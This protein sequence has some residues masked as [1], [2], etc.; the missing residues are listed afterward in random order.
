MGK[1]TISKQDASVD[2][3][4]AD[5]IARYEP[6]DIETELLQW[7]YSEYQ[8]MRQV[9]SQK[10]PE[11]NDRTLIEFLDDCQ[12]RANAYVPSR[13][14]QGKDEWQANI[15]TQYTRNKIKAFAASA[16]KTP[17]DVKMIARNTENQVSIRRAEIM[18][19]MVRASYLAYGNNPEKVIFNDAWNCL[20]NGTKISYDGFLKTKG[21]VK[22]VTS[23]DQVTGEVKFTEKEQIIEDCAIEINISPKNF[24]IKNAY[25]SDVQKQPT[26]AWVELYDEERF[27]AEFGHYKNAKFVR[28][29][30]QIISQNDVQ[31]FFGNEWVNRIEKKM[32]EVVR[33]YNKKLDRY[34]T[35]T[36]G[37]LLLNS[38]LL[39]G[40][41][42]KRYPF[43]KSGF[44][45]FANTEFFW[46]NSMANILMANQDVANTFI[47]GMVDKT[48]RT[49]KNAMI[50][51]MTN[52]D[53]FDLED[54][55][56]DQDT[57]IYVDDVNQVK[58]LPIEGVTASE[59][60]MLK[61]IVGGIE[62]ASVDQVQSGASGSGSTAREVVIANERA[63][64]LKNTFFMFLKDLWIQKYEIR[65]LNILMNY[66]E[67]QID[68]S[69]EPDDAEEFKKFRTFTSTNHKLKSG[70][71]GTLM[72]RIAPQDKHSRPSD[73]AAQEDA[74]KM[75]GMPT[76]IIEVDPK[77]LDDWDYE[78]EIMTETLFDHNKSLDMALVDEKVKGVATLFPN[79]FMQSNDE[80]FK[81]YIEGYG[82]NPD[83]Y[84]SAM[85]QQQPP[86]AGMMGQGQ[87]PQG[88]QMASAMP[89]GAQKLPQ[90]SGV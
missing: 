47:N 38:P 63:E 71:V 14:A 30:S 18:S 28:T 24:F 69:V 81:E 46:M 77:A 1:K 15:F 17:P 45:P 50:I 76:E 64:Q 29:G 33:I 60:N 74:Y 57:K 66:G 59:F 35:M 82:D 13:E 54:E 65:I 44:E 37:V 2:S 84:L 58:P 67:G 80:F 90:L 49:L 40:N 9:H 22:T 79:I 75:Q 27:N 72:I 16:S 88:Q 87:Q 42:R 51:G 48:N 53:M 26:V 85:N 34:L 62:E 23:F 70:A 52:K 73:L 5:D 86:M 21:T 7:A 4:G 68:A 12:K 43:P 39:W 83:K 25:I 32:Y 20:V 10:Y 56:V 8:I 36:N 61:V 19:A 78:F 55:Y 3:V 31:T 41:R 11:F 89:Q 6:T